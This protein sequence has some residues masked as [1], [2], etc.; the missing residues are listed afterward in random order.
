[1]VE[2]ASQRCLPIRLT[3]VL[4]GLLDGVTAE[5]VVHAVAIG[6]SRVDQMRAGQLPQQ[7]ISRLWCRVRESGSG[8]RVSVWAGVKAEQPERSG[9]VGTQVPV[10]PGEH[11]P[12]RSAGVAIRV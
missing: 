3:V 2:Q 11:S 9:R 6:M 5:Q 10:G 7:S 1:M 4:K 12:D 8:V